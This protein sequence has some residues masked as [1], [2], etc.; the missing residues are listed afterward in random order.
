VL[1]QIGAGALGPVF[2]AYQPE[3][4]RLV[5]VKL[6]R[7]DLEPERAHQLVAEFERLIAAD[8]SHPGIAAP[9]A[10]GLTDVHVYLAQDFVAAESLDVV[11]RDS[12]PAL[13]ETLVRVATQLGSALDHA[14]GAAILHGALHPRDI[15]M[16]SDD[17]RMTGIGV[18]RALAQVGVPAPVR[19][20]YTAPE[21]V[22][23]LPWDQRA[24]VFGLA[25]LLFELLTGRRVSGVG[26]EAAS[27]LPDTLAP[28]ERQAL[29]PVFAK[30][31]AGNPAGRYDSGAA[32]AQAITDAIGAARPARRESKRKRFGA[33][34]PSLLADLAPS[35]TADRDPS[36]AASSV[37]T[38][39]PGTDSDSSVFVPE[40]PSPES[41][42]VVPEL[43]SFASRVEAPELSSLEPPTAVEDGRHDLGE[44]H[45]TAPPLDQDPLDLHLVSEASPLLLDD[46]LKAMELASAAARHAEYPLDDSTPADVAAATEP[47]ADLLREQTPASLA[48]FQREPASPR[49]KRSAPG[50]AAKRTEST[51]GGDVEAVHRDEERAADLVTRP[52]VASPELPHEPDHIPS[53]ERVAAPA[54]A[55]IEEPPSRIRA[56][57]PLAAALVVGI[58]IGFGLAMIVMDRD[59]NATAAERTAIAAPPTAISEPP[60]VPSGAATVP[61][62]RM[63]EPSPGAAAVRP[64]TRTDPVPAKPVVP[65]AKTAVSPAA[66]GRLVVH[67]TPPGATVVVDG[68]EVGVTPLTQ[69]DLTAGTHLVRVTH[70]G[71]I[72]VER[73]V[74]I[75]DAKPSQ[76]I[77]IEL[78]R[79]N[80]E[81]RPTAPAAPAAAPAAKP[82]PGAGR[83]TLVVE[84]RPAGAE[85]F[86]DGKL[87]GT[88]PLVLES[89]PSGEH[90]V[91]LDRQGYRRWATPVTITP[92]E[93]SRLAASLEQ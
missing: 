10:T 54:F 57:G 13:F 63:P 77:A 61:S 60:I 14:A 7:L 23:G 42:V 58:G 85:V 72:S 27:L 52:P 16:S 71:Y 75:T 59:R 30:A 29:R 39:A 1:H 21:R 78:E 84:S 15:L 40:P 79:A 8:L 66:A 9:L 24:D 69:R 89:V 76:S 55:Q 3:Q 50:R 36:V 91:H 90:A 67:S 11:I 92:G 83:G 70:G 86:M 18:T 28:A 74:A 56:L 6:F 87:V 34:A 62:P 44:L 46:P 93:R 20:P 32:L 22:A 82:V 65:S 64:Q 43:P 35:S 51:V 80:V 31:L 17:A 88:T 25:A 47:S 41:R 4:D 81:R 73:H 49:T 2:R 19:R 12:G 26:D 68:K 48:Q 53:Y 37:E 5:A 45:L 38:S 33:D